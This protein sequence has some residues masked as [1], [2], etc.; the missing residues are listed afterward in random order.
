MIKVN[1]T[2]RGR[3]GNAIF[4]YMACAII[5]MEQDVEYVVEQHQSFNLNESDFT[6]ILNNNS[7]KI[8]KSINMN[9]FYQHDYRIHKTQIIKFINDNTH[10]ILTDGVNAGDG[11]KQSFLMKDILNTPSHFNK[12][13]KTVL[14]IRLEDFVT[15]GLNLP[16]SRVINCIKKITNILN[17]CVVCKQPT[18][19]FENNYLHNIK[20][21][22]DKVKINIIFEHN[23]ILTDYY[24]MKESTTLICSSSTLSWSA[25]FYSNKIQTC[26][27]PDYVGT[28]NQSC[29]RP[30]DNT[31][32]Y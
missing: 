20:Q 31:I 6:R 11:N 24:I 17:L 26:Y 19:E 13:Y 3:L 22:C 2:P 30:I 12:Q 25:A 1:F 8:N 14:H 23:D 4:R 18:T 7:L 27:F 10:H 5:C 15:H 28:P 21:Y 32:L 9:D 29:K 16:A